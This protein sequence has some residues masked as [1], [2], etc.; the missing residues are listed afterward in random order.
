MLFLTINRLNHIAFASVIFVVV[1]SVDVV[2]VIY[3]R[4]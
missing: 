1:V 4:I 3:D 2:V